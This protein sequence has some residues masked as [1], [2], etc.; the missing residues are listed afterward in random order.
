MAK[1]LHD[2]VSRVKKFNLLGTTTFV[3][4]RLADVFFQYA[5]LRRGW[6]AQVIEKLGGRPVSPSQVFASSA[7]GLQPY[8]VII[9]LMALGSSVKQ[10]VAMLVVSQQ[11]TPF[12]SAVTIAFFNTVFNSLNSIFSVWT[13]ASNYPPS[14]AGLLQSPTFGGF[15]VLHGRH[16]HRNGI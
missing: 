4:L 5:L 6:A 1:K 13:S 10:A 3:G 16:R 14:D 2:N 12:S 9:A 11:D 15:W 8:F 7:L